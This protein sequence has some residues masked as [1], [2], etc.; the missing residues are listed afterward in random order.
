MINLQNRHSRSATVD[1]FCSGPALLWTLACIWFLCSG[2]SCKGLTFF[3]SLPGSLHVFSFAQRPGEYGKVYCA[4][5]LSSPSPQRLTGTKVPQKLHIL[6]PCSAQ[7]HRRQTQEA[8]Y[9][10]LWGH[11]GTQ[12][13]RDSYC[14]FKLVCKGPQ[15]H[16]DPVSLTFP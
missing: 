7:E 5:S 13:W 11:L 16:T 8:F 6:L 15:E 1:E 14:W 9:P 2:Y 10:C 12:K 4:H 3:C